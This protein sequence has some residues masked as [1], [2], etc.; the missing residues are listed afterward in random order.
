MSVRFP[1]CDKN[2]QGSVLYKEER[3]ILAYSKSSWSLDLFG[4]VAAWCLTVEAL[5]RATPHTSVVTKNRGLGREGRWMEM[6]QCPL[7]GPCFLMGSQPPDG[8]TSCQPTLQHLSLGSSKQENLNLPLSPCS[9]VC[10][11]DPLEALSLKAV[12][13]HHLWIIR[14]LPWEKCISLDFFHSHL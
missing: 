1:H 8:A 2:T 13:K 14:K 11:H 10:L 12:M 4:P 9:S 5:G 6:L 3:F 7:S